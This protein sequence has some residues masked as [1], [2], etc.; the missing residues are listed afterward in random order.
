MRPFQIASIANRNLF[1]LLII[2]CCSL[3]VSA[4]ELGI[5]VGYATFAMADMKGINSN[6]LRSSYPVPLKLTSDFPPYFV[7]GLHGL[8][9]VN[10]LHTVELGFVTSLTSTGSRLSYSDYSGYVHVD[11]KLNGINVGFLSSFTLES[12]PAHKFTFDIKTGLTFTSYTIGQKSMVGPD[13]D[14]QEYSFKSID[15]F[16]EPG[17]SYRKK[18]NQLPLSLFCSVGYYI[19][20]IKGKVKLDSDS[21]AYLQTAN[22]GTAHVDW[23]GLRATAGV[24][25]Q[26][27]S[28]SY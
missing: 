21:N 15:V 10:P 5:T 12:K 26:L 18:L 11:Q 17:F 6:A 24:N 8:F 1:I 9:P 28:H 23:S 4:Q 7:F 27:R 19:S 13:A 14:N 16:A 20:A 22:G 2:T 3:H 25:F